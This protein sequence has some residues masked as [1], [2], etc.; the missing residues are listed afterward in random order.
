MEFENPYDDKRPPE[1]L[2]REELRARMI[3]RAK[4]TIAACEE[5]VASV[6]AWNDAHPECRPFDCEPERVLA[7]RTRQFLAA[8]ESEGT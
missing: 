7:H 2:T 4:W 8:L 5:I 6:Q 3:A 1:E